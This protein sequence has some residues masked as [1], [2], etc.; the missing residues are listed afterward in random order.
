MA[1]FPEYD[2]VLEVGTD[3]RG[4]KYTIRITNYL[5]DIIVRDEPNATLGLSLTSDIVVVN[6]SNAMLPGGL[7]GDIPV[8]SAVNPLGTVLFG[9]NVQP[10]EEASKLKLE[11]F[12]TQTN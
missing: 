9:S 1:A 8:M 5:N 11:I 12:Y 7:E 3:G 4:E 10:G 6:V 2:G